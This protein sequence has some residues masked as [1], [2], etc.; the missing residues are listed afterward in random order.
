MRAPK[1]AAVAVAVGLVQAAALTG[2]VP[3]AEASPSP[4]GIEHR[5]IPVCPSPPTGYAHCH[6]ILHQAVTTNGKPVTDVTTPSGIEPATYLQAYGWADS[7]GSRLIGD[8]AGQTIAVVDAYDDP[9]IAS[10][11][12]TFDSTFNLP[13]ASFTKVNQT[14]GTSYPSSNSGWALEISL[15]VEWAHAIAPAANILLVEA[16]TASFTNLMAAEDYAGAHAAYVTNSWGGSE[17]SGESSYDANFTAPGVSYFASAG[18]TGGAVEYPSAS[19]D[20]TSVGGTTL[21]SSG[22]TW[23]ET[24][25][26]SSG[27]GCSA[28]ESAAAGQVTTPINCN[29]TRATPDVA[30]D[31]DP[32]TGVAV[33]DSTPYSGQIGW[34]QVGGTS[35]ASPVWAARAADQGV[36]ITPSYLY[37]GYSGTDPYGTNIAYRDPTSGNNGY[38]A[39]PGFDLVTGLGTWTGVGGTTTAGGLAAPTGLAATANSDGS[40]GLAWSDTTGGVSYDVYRSTTSGAELSSQPVATGVTTTSWTDT[41]TSAGVTYYYEV[42][43]YDATATSPASNEASA[44]AAGT[45]TAPATITAAS[46]S[47]ADCSFSG[48]GSGTLTWSFGDGTGATGS[49]VS[50]TYVAAGTYPVTLTDSTP[51]TAKASVICSTSHSRKH[52][53]LSCS[54]TIG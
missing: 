17:F 26:S 34:F 41:S 42:E 47:K 22:G 30:S 43:A 14:G 27:G 45:T 12:A 13:T 44:T 16:S 15:D 24:G 4:Q 18:D 31:A 54:A 35:A 2:S 50:H 51:T 39:G 6:A 29:G 23:S 32:N 8:G 9:T 48:T 28:Y 52:P 53:D 7:T 11:L 10:D 38:P 49:P 20:V 36:Q 37:A 3:A 19:P 40:I 1:L 21:T 33:Y 46:C 25:W 5:N